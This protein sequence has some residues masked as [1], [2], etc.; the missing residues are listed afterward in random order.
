MRR[1]GTRV[2]EGL[3]F[4]FRVKMNPDLEQSMTSVNLD[5]AK[6]F[7]PDNICERAFKYGKEENMV[8]LVLQLK[9]NLN[10]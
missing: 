1:E 6:N 4:T 7:F 8:D 10:L 3:I 2:L 9:D 5:S